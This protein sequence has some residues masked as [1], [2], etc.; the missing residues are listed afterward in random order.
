MVSTVQSLFS[1][2]LSILIC[3]LAALLLVAAC[4][5][6]EEYVNPFPPCEK[7]VDT[8][9]LSDLGDDEQVSFEKHYAIYLLRAQ[10]VRDKY[11]DL[12]ESVPYYR[13]VS[14]T[15]LENKDGESLA[16]WGIKVWV[17]APGEHP[18]EGLEPPYEQPIRCLESVPIQ[19]GQFRWQHIWFN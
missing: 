13:S 12:I 4:S 14:F 7:E 2:L 3:S 18:I 19:V 15:H 17:R 6:G 10:A 1:R 9:L 5:G 11:S 8:R 16:A